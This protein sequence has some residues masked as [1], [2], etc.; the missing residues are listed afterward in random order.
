VALAGVP[1]VDA[2]PGHAS[3]LG[4][5]ARHL[6]PAEV[7]RALA[8]A[9]LD[10]DRQTAAPGGGAG[11]RDRPIGIVEQRRSGAGL[12]HLRDRA[13]HVDVDQIGARRGHP[14]RGRLHH[15][16]IV[17]EQL[18]GHRVLVRMDPQQLAAGALV[19]VVHGEARDHLRDRQPGAVAL[20]L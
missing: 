6:D 16:R 5:P 3:V 11:Q 14:L 17:A 19:A 7:T 4:Q 15:V 13:A 9:Q 18:H 20:G 1:R 8:R 10:G 12:A 2:Q